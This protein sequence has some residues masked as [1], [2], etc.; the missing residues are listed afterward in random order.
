VVGRWRKKLAEEVKP[1]ETTKRPERAVV[2]LHVKELEFGAFRAFQVVVPTPALA[3]FLSAWTRVGG[4]T[5]EVCPLD[6]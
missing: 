1:E 2:T 5:F 3:E 4:R 6:D